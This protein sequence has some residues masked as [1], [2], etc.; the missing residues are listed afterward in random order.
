MLLTVL[1]DGCEDR[2]NLYVHMM[3]EWELYCVCSYLVASCSSVVDGDVG[4][5]LSFVDAERWWCCK[6]NCFM[7]R[8]LVVAKRV[9]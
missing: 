3:F 4:L 6:P 7:L 2:R 9:G 1:V 5:V 8:G